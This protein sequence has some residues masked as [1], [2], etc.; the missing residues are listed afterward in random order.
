MV[1]SSLI[2]KDGGDGITRLTREAAKPAANIGS[3]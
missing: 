2:A 3:L 1:K